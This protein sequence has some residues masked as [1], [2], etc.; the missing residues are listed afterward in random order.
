[1]TQTTLME[2]L[3]NLINLGP[4]GSVEIIKT[5]D[6]HYL[7]RKA[8]NIGFNIYIGQPSKPHDGPGLTRSLAIWDSWTQN[9]RESVVAL[10]E[11]LGIDLI[12]EFGIPCMP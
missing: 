10:S 9:K 1:M 11:S 2:D 3:I 8:G 4:T 12:K 6:G 7:G 5:S